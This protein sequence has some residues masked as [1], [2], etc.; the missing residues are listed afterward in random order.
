MKSILLLLLLVIG[1]QAY[2]FE[3]PE[4]REKNIFYKA[5][6]K[7]AGQSTWFIYGIVL[8]RMKIKLQ[9][10]QPYHRYAYNWSKLLNM[11]LHKKPRANS[12]AVF[13]YNRNGHLIFVVD[14]EGRDIFFREANID[15]N[16]HVGYKDGDLQVGKI[17]KFEKGLVGYLYP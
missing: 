8:E 3:K 11:K 13:D 4:Y 9:F 16:R 6:K 17:T 12:I 14:V 1:I 5:N 10:S 2:D 15:D 7:L